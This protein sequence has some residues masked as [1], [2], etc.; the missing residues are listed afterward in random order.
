MFE[1]VGNGLFF[2]IRFLVEHKNDKFIWYITKNTIKD[3]KK[4][5]DFVHNLK[6]HV[7]T[8]CCFELRILLVHLNAF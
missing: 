6:W 5:A 1:M 3:G 8:V 7:F 4:N 2:I